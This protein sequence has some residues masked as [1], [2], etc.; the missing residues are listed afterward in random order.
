LRST[1]MSKNTVKSKASSV[2]PSHADHPAS[3]WSLVGSLHQH[4]PLSRALPFVFSSLA[5]VLLN[6]RTAAAGRRPRDNRSFISLRHIGALG[7]IKGQSL[8]AGSSSAPSQVSAATR[9]L[10]KDFEASSTPSADAWILIAS[11]RPLSPRLAR[12]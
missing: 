3:H 1:M 11:V 9:R 2:K 12:H 10:A 5:G 8:D 4:R 6:R 7:H